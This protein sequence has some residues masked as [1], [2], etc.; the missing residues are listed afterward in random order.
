MWAQSFATLNVP[1]KGLI[2]RI[3][4]NVNYFSR[5]TVNEDGGMT[6]HP[7]NSMSRSHVELPAEMDILA[8]IRNCPQLNNPCNAY[9]PTPIEVSI[10]DGQDC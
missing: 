7:R 1:L 8:P 9:N 2:R 4:A 5:A 3:P 10:W 6:L